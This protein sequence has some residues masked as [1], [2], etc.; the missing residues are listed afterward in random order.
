[1]SFT[2]GSRIAACKRISGEATDAVAYGNVFNDRA[3][4][5]WSTRTYARISAAFILTGQMM[6]TLF[7]DNA[8]G[9]TIWWSTDIIFD[10]RT[11]RTIAH[12]STVRIWT[13][14]R[15]YTWV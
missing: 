1:M 6:W 3:C 11:G 4:G 13:T 9:S 14:R 12:Y 15:W 10:T 5:M 8:L 7:I 2:L